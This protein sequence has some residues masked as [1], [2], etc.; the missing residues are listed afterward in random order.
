MLSTACRV[1]QR[2]LRRECR[3]FLDLEEAKADRVEVARSLLLK[4][5]EHC[6]ERETDKKVFRRRRVLILAH[7][8]EESFVA[9]R[10]ILSTL[11]DDFV[12]FG[13]LYLLKG[14]G[15][16][17]CVFMVRVCVLPEFHWLRCYSAVSRGNR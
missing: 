15:P 11:N 6:P 4:A 3:A 12:L 16:V 1:E 2:D 13:R 9:K 14:E 5:L 7:L 10:Y 17:G 8:G